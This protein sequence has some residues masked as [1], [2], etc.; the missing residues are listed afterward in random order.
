MVLD[1]ETEIWV[2]RGLRTIGLRTL[3]DNRHTT[4]GASTR[5]ILL[6]F[7]ELWPAVLRKDHRGPFGERHPAQLDDELAATD[8]KGGGALVDR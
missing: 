2:L 3:A 7:G 8:P 6:P 1:K 5:K 4:L